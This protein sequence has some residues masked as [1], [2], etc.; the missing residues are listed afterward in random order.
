M[1]L[2][3]GLYIAQQGPAAAAST[4]MH[5]PPAMA[6]TNPRMGGLGGNSTIWIIAIAAVVLG[7]AVFSVRIGR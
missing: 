2:N 6:S 1:A 4:A 5:A 3:S 7:Y